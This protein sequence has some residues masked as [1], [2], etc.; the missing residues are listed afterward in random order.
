MLRNKVI[1]FFRFWIIIIITPV[2]LLTG[3]PSPKPI[4]QT[5][6]P[7]PAVESPRQMKITIGSIDLSNHQK[8]IE[9]KDI[10]KFA[11]Q[12]KKDS[13][14][15]L[16]IQGMTR[17]PALKNRIDIFK[18]ITTSTEMISVFGETMTLSGRQ[19]GNAIF[20]NYPIKS[21]EST[22]YTQI[23]STG[24]ENALQAIIDCGERELVIVSTKLPEK[25]TSNDRAVIS[26]TLGKFSI[27]YTN[28]PVIITGNLLKINTTSLLNT[29]HTIEEEKYPQKFWYSNN[30]S[31]R[32]NNLK[33]ASTS[34][35]KM[36]Q[37]SFMVS[38]DIN[39]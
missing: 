32:I 34:L 35:G 33:I 10:K 18:E 4:Q 23:S 17:Y 24:F 7:P 1:K 26:S 30:G 39:P 19:N 31:L 29:Y 8:K 13:L 37:V 27:F 21:H 25:L 16:T 38:T 11:R 5:K 15:I 9:L 2:I 28:R 22:P 3:C 12:V 20:S 14:D 6:I 36:I